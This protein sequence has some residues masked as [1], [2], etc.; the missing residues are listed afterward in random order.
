MDK[1]QISTG[2]I[3]SVAD[4]RD[5]SA[6]IYP[7]G[8]IEDEIYTNIDDVVKYVYQKQIGACT[9]CA[10]VK[11]IEYLFYKKTGV[12]TQ[13][14]VRFLYNITKQYIDCNTNEGSS[15]R[16]ALKAS[17]KYGVMTE[18]DCPSNFD[19]THSE[20]ISLVITQ[21]MLL[22]ASKYKIG[23]YY[24]I[25]VESSIIHYALKRFGTL[26]ARFEV[27]DTWYKPTWN[28]SDILPL[29]QSSNIIS[30]HAVGIFKSNIVTKT[31]WLFNS[32]SRLWADNG[33][34]YYVYDDYKPTELWA[35]TL[36][37][38]PEIKV[39]SSKTIED[40]TW[41]KFLDILRLVKVIK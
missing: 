1:N 3:P 30:G 13:L 14:S 4:S 23:A 33:N 27:G 10:L 6:T 36:D 32:W 8:I 35:V 2:A 17:Q 5:F 19:T 21:D 24:S 12:Y 29:K 38:I 15:L 37:P 7:T 11:I 25:P 16:N 40:K 22:K 28:K 26:Y 41:R 9:A 20:F 18:Q 31:Q 34:G 39:D